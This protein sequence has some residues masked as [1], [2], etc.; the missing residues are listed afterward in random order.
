MG[1]GEER[2]WGKKGNVADINSLERGERKKKLITG[3][4]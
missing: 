4:S 2:D 3:I 1:P